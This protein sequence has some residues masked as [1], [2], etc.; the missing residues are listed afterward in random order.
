MHVERAAEELTE[1]KV[2]RRGLLTGIA[3]LGAAALVKL[4]GTEKAEAA[5]EP[6]D[7]GLAIVN[8]S[9][10]G[11]T[12]VTTLLNAGISN[13]AGFQVVNGGV[14]VAG[15]SGIVGVTDAV[16][17]GGV[18]GYN[19]SAIGFGVGGDSADGTGVQGYS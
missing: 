6:L 7:M 19:D 4:S 13:N 8:P 18:R 9:A 16:G 10:G 1:R 17:G 2:V 5:H 11:T 12:A 14:A 3:A 15:K